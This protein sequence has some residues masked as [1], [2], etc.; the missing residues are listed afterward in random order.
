MG[1][2][3]RDSVPR[4]QQVIDSA[5]RIFWLVSLLSRDQVVC[6]FGDEVL[7]LMGEKPFQ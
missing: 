1:D 6:E 3:I 2:R 4:V 7:F 5:V